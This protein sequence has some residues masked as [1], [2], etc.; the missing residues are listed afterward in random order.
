MPAQV[1][2]SAK[3][4]S[5]IK[6]SPPSRS[7]AFPWVRGVL[8]EFNLVKPRAE[9]TR[10]FRDAAWEAL[11]ESGLLATLHDICHEV[12]AEA[13]WTV[14]TE[15]RLRKP[16]RRPARYVFTK[17]RVDFAVGIEIGKRELRV[18]F[19][20]RNLVPDR[21]PSYRKYLYRYLVRHLHEHRRIGLSL[22]NLKELPTESWFRYLMSGFDASLEDA[23]FPQ[24]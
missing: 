5:P 24:L 11:E 6:G 23:L 16:H 17:D 20:T 10:P 3:G 12:N 13:G 2:P 9:P 19:R 7:A 4:V 8:H 14:L 15:E 1:V 22:A 18:V 21:T